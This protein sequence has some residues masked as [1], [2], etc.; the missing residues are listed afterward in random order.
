MSANVNNPMND[1]RNIKW[2]LEI[3]REHYCDQPYIVITASGD[4]VCVMTTGA[5]VES[6]DSM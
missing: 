5:G 6:G 2:G 4:W 3:P 1:V